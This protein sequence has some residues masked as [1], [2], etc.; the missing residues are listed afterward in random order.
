MAILKSTRKRRRSGVSDS[1]TPAVKSISR[2]GSVL[3]SLGNGCDTITDISSFCKLSKSTV[4]RLLKALEENHLV[5]QNPISHRYYLGPQ[6]TRFALSPGNT[7][8]FLISNVH[9][10][11]QRLADFSRETVMLSILIGIQCIQLHEVPSPYD[12]RISGQIGGV[13]P[14][15]AGATAK[16]LLAELPEPELENAV[17]YLE[18]SPIT[19]QTVTDKDLLLHQLE[20]IREQ[21]YA[22]TDGEMFMGVTCVAA[23][24]RSYVLPAVISVVGP[25]SRL[26]PRIEE[27]THELLAGT[28]RITRKLKKLFGPELR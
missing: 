15:L 24:V 3:V 1:G 12:L 20:M 14:T 23:P 21:G 5:S 19:A 17:K 10:E 2:A 27:V 18:V 16:A 11:M 26:K 28:A 13:L 4:H 25:E 7:H 22:I 8:D 6:F 9:H